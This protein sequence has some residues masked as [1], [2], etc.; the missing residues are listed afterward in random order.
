MNCC[1]LQFFCKIQRIRANVFGFKDCLPFNLASGVVYKYTRG[2]CRSSYYDEMDRVLK[3][4]S[5]EYINISPLKFR[6]V[7]PSKESESPKLQKYPMLLRV[8]RLGIW[9]S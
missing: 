2:R 5:G 1:N 9:T 4:R 6:E 8:Y 7:K 3:V